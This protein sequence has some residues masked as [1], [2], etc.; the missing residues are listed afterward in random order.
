MEAEHQHSAG[1]SICPDRFR[2]G[3]APLRK[4][5]AKTFQVPLEPLRWLVVGCAGLAFL[6]FVLPFSP[7]PPCP[8]LTITGVPCPLCGMTRSVRSAMRFDLGQSLTFQPFGL[9][10]L[11]AGVLIL[12]TWALP[13][14]RSVKVLRVPAVACIAVICASWVWN[15]AFNPTFA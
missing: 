5:L 8:L 14:T 1:D 11:I 2:N 9:P 7:I 6:G 10:A 13:K 4:R 12:G 3:R 15:I